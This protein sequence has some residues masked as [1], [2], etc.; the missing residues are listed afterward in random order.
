M[1]ATIK[2]IVF[3]GPSSLQFGALPNHVSDC[4]E[5]SWEKLTLFIYRRKRNVAAQVAE[6]LNTVTFATP[7][8]EERKKEPPKKTIHSAHSVWSGV[9]LL[10]TA[11]NKYNTPRKRIF[12]GRINKMASH[13]IN[14]CKVKVT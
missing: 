11:F 5:S 6:E 8:M 9:D 13:Y 1:I 12:N 3:I 2:P 7:P 14:T 4:F 10:A